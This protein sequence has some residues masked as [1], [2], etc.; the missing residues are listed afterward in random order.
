MS[1]FLLAYMFNIVINMSHRKF[2]TA[3]VIAVFVSN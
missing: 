1:L 2:V 3:D